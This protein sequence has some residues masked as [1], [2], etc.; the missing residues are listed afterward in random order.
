MNYSESEQLASIWRQQGAQI[1]DFDASA[2]Y[3]VY[4]KVS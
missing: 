3:A 1:V 4:S 2:F